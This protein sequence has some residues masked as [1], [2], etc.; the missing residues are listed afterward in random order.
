[1]LKYFVL[2]LTGLL[3][4][5][6]A[7]AQS[8]RLRGLEA[9]DS[10][11]QHYQA[12][13]EKR[14]ARFLQRSGSGRVLTQGNGSK[15]FL[16][17]VSPSG[18][19]IY[20]KSDNAEVATSLNVDE[21]RSTGSLGLNLEGTGIQLGIWDEGRVRNNHVE[22]GGR[23]TQIDNPSP[24]FNFHA[25]HVMG[26]MLAAGINAN[27]KGMAPKATAIAFDFN[28]DVSEMS[29]QA[30][31][32]QTSIVLS[33]H[34][35][36]TLS[37]WDNGTGNWVWHGD[38]SI[39]NSI[40]WKFGFYNSTS[41]FYDDI[42]FNAPYYLI[43]K[44]AGNDNSDVG[45]GSRPADCNPFDCIPTNGVAKNILTVG[46]VKKLSGP[47]TGPSDVEITSFSSFGPSDDGRIKPDIVAPGQA[48]LS[49]SEATTTSYA[50]ASGTS[51]SSPA[52]T[53]TLALLQELYK[54]LNGGNLMKAATLKA[55]AIH[56][57]REAGTSPGP[58]FK[59][60][61][62]LLDAKAAAETI[63][64][65]DDQNIFIQELSLSNGNVFEMNL[66]PKENEKI[67]A[68]LV[69]TD[70]AGPVLTPSL[71][72]TTKTLVNNLNLSLID[73]GGTTQ[74]PWKLNAAN[75]AAAATKGINT[76]DNVE[77]LEFDLPEPR[78]YKL[79]VDHS[80]TLVNGS[81]D[82]SLILTY[83]SVIDPR[84]K[85]YWIGNTGNWNDGAKWSLSSGGV[86]AN[87]VPG[88]ED[89]V[90]FD[91]N[92]FSADNQILSLTQDQ[93]CY[94]IRWFANES[95]QWSLNGHH[96][97][98]GAGVNL[99]TDNI[100]TT[101]AGSLTLLGL[102]EGENPVSLGGNDLND[103]TVEFSGP[104]SWLLTGDVSLSGISLAEG[105]LKING[106]SISLSNIGFTGVASKSMT[107][108]NATITGLGTV[109]IDWSG[110]ELEVVNS[111]LR[112]PAA[113]TFS[114][115]LGS[116]MFEGI[117]ELDGGQLNVTGSG[118]IAKVMGM[119]TLVTQSD[120]I[121]DDILL[122]AGST[123]TIQEGSQQTVNGTFDLAGT[124]GSKVLVESSGPGLATLNFELNQKICLDHLTIN[125]VEVTGESTVSAGLNS[126]VTNSPGWIADDCSNI[127]FADFE[128]AFNCENA[129]VYFTDKS[130]GPISSRTWNFGD[131]AS[132]VNESQEANPI[133]FFEGPGQHDVTLTVSNG[134]SNDS[135]QKTIEL[136][137]SV[138]AENR[139]EFNN[140]KLISFQPAEG[141]QWV[142][143]GKILDGVDTRS[144]DFSN[145]FGE[146]SVL[147]F[148][149]LCNRRSEPFLVTGLNG[150]FA[151]SGLYLYPNPATTQLSILFG[152]P[153]TGIKITD[154]LGRSLFPAW[155]K[156]SD[157]AEIDISEFPGGIYILHVQSESRIIYRRVV[158]R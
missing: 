3:T 20:I 45:D 153:V 152:K 89:N 75:P 104:A 157:G 5:N 131:D 80:G 30:K 41:R 141:Y 65:R 92:S 114:V 126:T 149:E 105:S 94:S 103:L 9:V 112:C 143:D 135:Y 121:W 6:L 42:A 145:G 113:S 49:T 40:D 74:F 53:G 111:T 24:S 67:T 38:P 34:S 27:A 36:G 128:V 125:N 147:T 142:L 70:P 107:F 13:A 66:T 97:E 86:P 35:Y 117:I 98:V 61:W 99:L 81:Q 39:S 95:V 91:E 108:E 56:T 60:G 43:V 130:S 7:P 158:F 50:T 46:A 96:L 23:V 54:N 150:D 72:P 87:A 116:N 4:F 58:D 21:L 155:T 2:L 154:Q 136:L 101:S 123:L 11:Y 73:D 83:S 127:L 37:G 122:E 33:N 134:T 10:A 124:A 119:G 1:M 64:N 71:N 52:T 100:T 84:T 28:G 51:M 144:I 102:G 138:L 57:A 15:I 63:I 85:Y 148:D 68:T 62:G 19:P 47:Y 77:K 22:F 140:G 76:V 17:D 151:G 78:D 32:D 137:P 132:Q 129:S 110:V 93:Q 55:L 115:D 8:N 12:E 90:I 18:I 106:S 79:R 14:I 133:H 146:Y 29:N 139:I 82:F 31:P 109:M 88:S 48:V 120:L 69:W 118:E 16:I 59:F 25:T 156:T 44:S 26:T